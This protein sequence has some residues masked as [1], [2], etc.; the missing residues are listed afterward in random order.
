M[1]SAQLA[2]AL[3]PRARASEAVMTTAVGGR[4]GA[5]VGGGAT[6]CAAACGAKASVAS[7]ALA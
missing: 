6:A 4:E 3:V 2:L 7:S 1:S 5:G